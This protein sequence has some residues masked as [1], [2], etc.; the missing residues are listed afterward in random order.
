MKGTIHEPFH[1]S[2]NIKSLIRSQKIS[3]IP[4]LDRSYVEKNIVNLIRKTEP[5]NSSFSSFYK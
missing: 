2:F 1:H 4:I 5:S 3:Q